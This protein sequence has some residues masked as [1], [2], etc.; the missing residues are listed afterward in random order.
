[1]PILPDSKSKKFPLLAAIFNFLLPGL[2]Y[3]YNAKRNLFA[4]LFLVVSITF[5]V[6]EWYL[7]SHNLPIDPD[8]SAWP[9]WILIATE[10]TYFILSLAFAI[11][12]FNEAKILNKENNHSQ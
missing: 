7:V 9:L 11:D 10:A 4:F 2:G 3:A 12:A 1:M 8:K 6:T 5:W